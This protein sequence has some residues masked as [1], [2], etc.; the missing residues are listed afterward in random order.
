VFIHGEASEVRAVRHHL[1]TE[2]G[3]DLRSA[4]ISPYWRRDHTDEQWRSIKPRWL[5][6]QE[7]DA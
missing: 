2:R 5:A 1:V 6:D 4:S 7:T 3:I